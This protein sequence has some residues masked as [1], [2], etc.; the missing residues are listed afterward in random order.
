MRFKIFNYNYGVSLFFVILGAA[1]FIILVLIFIA[2]VILRPLH[3]RDVL[4]YFSEDFLWLSFG[5]Q[6]IS[7]II[8]VI[9]QIIFWG[10]I[11]AVLFFTWKYFS[12]SYKLPVI[13]V[14][15]YF[16][17][18]LI[19][20]YLILLPLDYFRGYVIEHR[21][22]LSTQTI[23]GWVIDHL[24]SRLITFFI[25][26]MVM[27]VFYVL[28][29]RIRS[30]WWIFAGIFYVV[31]LFLSIYLSPL[32]IDPLFYNFKPIEDAQM[33]HK[34]TELTE[35]AGIE[36][37]E[38]LVADASRRTA[39]ASAYF[40]GIGKTRRIVIYDNLLKRFSEDEVIS[41]IAHEI[42]HW[43]YF[44]I[45][46]GFMMGAAGGFLAIFIFKI[47]LEKINIVGDIRALLIILLLTSLFSFVSLPFQNA[48]SRFFE[49]EAD[50]EA[51]HLVEDAEIYISLMQRLAKSNLSVVNPNP[52][53]KY[54]LYTHP[55]IMERIKFVISE[56]EDSS[57]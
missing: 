21:Y 25:L 1:A 53:V 9:R 13:R 29:S 23:G 38:V 35:K 30:N 14:A 6:R 32:I 34:I 49:K 17:L 39:R 10:F 43:K 41:V 7:L 19:F 11:L 54:I 47:I 42:G 46:K 24:K 26:M 12:I 4:R 8:Y 22:G 51:I 37:D 15:G 18:F 20:I 50:L 28:M 48:V 27:I 55:P 52:L 57:N 5:Y 44:H 31:F 33:N 40:T 56:V 36:V 3:N 45:L 16:S 2:G